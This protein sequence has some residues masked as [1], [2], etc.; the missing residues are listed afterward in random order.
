L[1]LVELAIETLAVEQLFMA[2]LF[3]DASFIFVLSMKSRKQW[4]DL[5]LDAE[6]R[7]KHLVQ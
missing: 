7:Q 5:T 2:T 1:E 4:Y 6:K 3:Y